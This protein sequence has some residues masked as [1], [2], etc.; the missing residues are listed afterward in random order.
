MKEKK[1]Q[2]LTLLLISILGLFLFNTNIFAKNIKRT[3][4]AEYSIYMYDARVPNTT[5]VLFRINQEA[6]GTAVESYRKFT[7]KGGCGKLV[8]NRC[9]KRARNA[10]LDCTRAHAKHPSKTPAECNSKN[11]MNY[12][13]NDFN[14]LIK[15]TV[16]LWIGSQ[17]GVD[18]SFLQ[19]PF[20]VD[21]LVKINING[22]K[23]CGKKN[24]ANIDIGGQ[25][26]KVYGNDSYLKEPLKRYKILCQPADCGCPKWSGGCGTGI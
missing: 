24:P 5:R 22:K 16:C 6:K 23:G 19:E 18:K 20:E 1:L 26:Y 2:K 17:R 10:I 12:K 21:T 11:I 25:T 4:N 3:C 14:T 7:A 9:R 13:I 15:K 8:P